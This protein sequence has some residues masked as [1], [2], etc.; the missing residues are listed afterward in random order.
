MIINE[1]DLNEIR[2]Y[3]TEEGFAEFLD[4]CI[5]HIS[6]HIDD[7]E[8]RTIGSQQL[9]APAH[10][11]IGSAGVIGATKAEAIARSLEA[12]CVAKDEPVV[13]RLITELIAA[14]AETA[15]ELKKLRA[16]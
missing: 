12:A 4:Q 3:L 10:S 13:S 8:S 1:A 9:L 5:T 2:L 7:L 6:S 11:M 14:W 15:H 16:N